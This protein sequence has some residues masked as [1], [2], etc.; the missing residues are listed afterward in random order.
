MALYGA[1]AYNS[2]LPAGGL[3]VPLAFGSRREGDGADRKGAYPSGHDHLH[4]LRGKMKWPT[5]WQARRSSLHGVS[6]ADQ[7]VNLAFPL[8]P[9]AITRR[10]LGESRS[11]VHKGVSAFDIRENVRGRSGVLQKHWSSWLNRDMGFK[12]RRCGSP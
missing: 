8:S 3:S 5:M 9:A 11:P 1:A 2:R 10:Q 6:A 4:G 7:G 12:S